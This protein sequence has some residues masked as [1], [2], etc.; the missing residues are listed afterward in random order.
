VPRPMGVDY[1]G[2]AATYDHTR[3]SPREV[4]EFWLPAVGLDAGV[5]S[6]SRLLDVGCGT[7]RLAVPL[8]L[9]CRVVG[10]DVSREMIGVARAKGSPATF[11]LG[12]AGRLPFRDRTFDTALAVM[13]LHLVQDVRVAIHELARVA[14]RAVIATIDMAARK[15]HAIDEAFPS[16]DAIDRARFP[17]I[18][19]IVEACRAAGWTRVEVH[20]AHRRIESS[21]SEFLDRVRSRYVSTLTLLP[22]GEFERGL[23]WLE[24]DLPRRGDRYAYDHTVTFVNAS[25]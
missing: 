10:V 16:F 24:E 15:K 13:V 20:G 21:T 6:S 22:P 18:P 19:A 5:T 7:G 8:S 17:P 11:I 9:R 2:L 1:S 23:A 4:N 14:G 12:E 25:A 3:S